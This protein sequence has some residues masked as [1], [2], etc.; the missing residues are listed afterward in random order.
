MKAITK[1]ISDDGK[2]F[3][4]K[5]ECA[6]Y[7]RTEMCA[8]RLA[9]FIVQTVDRSIKDKEDRF[10]SYDAIPTGD[11]LDALVEDIP[12][13]IACLLGRKK[14]ATKKAIRIKRDVKSGNTG[15]LQTVKKLNE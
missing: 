4:T 11:I 13:T 5:K 6:E 2:E 1:Y 8:N 12:A 3:P 7:E 15:S 14:K 9:E 10:G